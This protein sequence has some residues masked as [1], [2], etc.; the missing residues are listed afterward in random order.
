M[1]G[2]ATCPGLPLCP[3]N[4]ALVAFGGPARATLTVGG[5]REANSESGR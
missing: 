5:A 3:P 1:S 2:G 4:G